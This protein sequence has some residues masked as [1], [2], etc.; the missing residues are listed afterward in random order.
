MVDSD[1]SVKCI[2]MGMGTFSNNKDDIENPILKI[3]HLFYFK[4]L[5]QQYFAHGVNNLEI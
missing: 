2:N 3:K 1:G 4:F 5:S